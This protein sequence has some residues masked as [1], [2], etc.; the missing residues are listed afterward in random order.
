MCLLRP[1][2]YLKRDKREPL[3]YWAEAQADL[4]L[5]W[6]H[7][8]VISVK[9]VTCSVTVFWL[10]EVSGYLRVFP[11]WLYGECGMWFYPNISDPVGFRPV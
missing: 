5:C 1:S 6:L 4:S 8:S 3:P 2:G 10:I 11:L 9:T 7:I